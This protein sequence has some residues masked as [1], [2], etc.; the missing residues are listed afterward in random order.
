MQHVERPGGSHEGVGRKKNVCARMEAGR[1]VL[2][3]RQQVFMLSGAALVVVFQRFLFCVVSS[4]TYSGVD[5]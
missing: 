4:R 2:G 1:G 5:D 3:R